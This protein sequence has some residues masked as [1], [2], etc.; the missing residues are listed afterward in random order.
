MVLVFQGFGVQRMQSCGIRKR[1]NGLFQPSYIC[2]AQSFRGF[3][4]FV[5]V[6]A[7]HGYH[8]T[9]ARV[10]IFSANS[11]HISSIKPDSTALKS[12]VAG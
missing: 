5:P 12:W 1:R 4:P 11:R 3:K 8:W 2:C 7:V 6:F 10:K 9:R